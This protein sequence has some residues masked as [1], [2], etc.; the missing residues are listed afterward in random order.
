MHARIDDGGSERERQIR[1]EH[2]TRTSGEASSGH[3]W[4]RTFT[5]GWR[6][7]PGQSRWHVAL[8][9]V[10]I[11]LGKTRCGTN[12]QPPARIADRLQRIVVGHRPTTSHAFGLKTP[13]RRHSPARRITPPRRPD[14]FPFRPCR[15]TTRHGLFYWT[16]R[17]VAGVCPGGQPGGESKFCPW[18]P[19][20]SHDPSSKTLVSALQL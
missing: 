4:S 20:C 8:P 18:R 1:T 16:T 6:S 2:R 11:G 5:D 14:H 9:L 15:A 19:R 13:V 7:P 12:V 10:S 3:R 17:P